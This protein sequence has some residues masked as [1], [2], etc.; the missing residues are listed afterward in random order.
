[1]QIIH[2]SQT[3]FFLPF[4]YVAWVTFK[5]HFQ[6]KSFLLQFF[7]GQ[8]TILNRLTRLLPK[9]TTAAAS[10]FEPETSGL[11]IRGLIHWS[12]ATPWRWLVILIVTCKVVLYLQASKSNNFP[13]YGP[14]NNLFFFFLPHVAQNPW[15]ILQYTF[16]C[17]VTVVCLFKK[18]IFIYVN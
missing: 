13:W 17:D 15:N 18:L 6:Q 2:I 8:A 1:M 9:S 14:G 7:L 5:R 3:C 4:W 11:R 12:T 16:K 10:R